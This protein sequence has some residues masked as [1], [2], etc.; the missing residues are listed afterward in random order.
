MKKRDPK[1]RSVSLGTKNIPFEL[2]NR[3]VKRLTIN[4]YPD[5]RVEVIAP[6]GKPLDEILKRVRKRAPWIQKQ[7][8][9]F[10]QYHPLP[11]RKKYV[12]GETHHY[13]GRQ[14]RL[15]IVKSKSE[16]VKLIGRYLYVYTPD[17]ENTWMIRSQL[18]KWYLSHA[19][20]IFL[21]RLE[22][23]LEMA[24]TLDVN[25]DQIIIR[26][27]KNRWGS[28]T[29]KRNIVLNTELVKVPVHCIEYV[30]MHELCHMKVAKHSPEFYRL[31]SRH[32]PD[33]EARKERLDR[34][35]H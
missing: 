11:T 10:D 5:K 25:P 24:P 21:R 29:K 16:A 19:R 13:L 6:H 26:R 23:C 9:H 31:L 27:M 28:F 20:T 8:N 32:M 3:N 1:Q 4:V 18:D 2:I 12:S 33:W 35:V 14:Y 22:R 7:L 34:F 15:K 30:I 17:R